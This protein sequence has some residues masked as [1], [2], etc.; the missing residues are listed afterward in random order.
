[1]IADAD[2][3]AEIKAAHLAAEGAQFNNELRN[4]FESVSVGFEAGKLRPDVH[5]EPDGLDAGQ[6][7]RETVR[8]RRGVQFDPELVLPPAGRDLRMG[9][10]VYIGVDPYPNRRGPA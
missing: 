7:R 1:M 8:G 4:S 2:T 5:C 6:L 10:R 3:T 9:L